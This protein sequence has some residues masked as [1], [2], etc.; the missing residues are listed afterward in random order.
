[1][2][3]LFL[4]SIVSLFALTPAYGQ[5]LSDATGLVNRLDVETGGHTFEVE[6]VSNFDISDFEFDVDEKRL[7]LHITS[8]LKNNLG[9]MQI[10]R[11]LLGGNFTFNL[12]DQQFFPKIKSNE[13]ISFV[14]L[15]F[16]GAGD[17]KLDIFGNISLSDLTEMAQK[18]SI[19]TPEEPEGDYSWWLVLAGSLCISGLIIVTKKKLLAK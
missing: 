2:K 19:P 6:V 12:N 8:G 10:P 1:L 4:I 9:E 5:I 13:R 18:E 16:T 14:T 7:T 11:E 3:V 17:N 15:N